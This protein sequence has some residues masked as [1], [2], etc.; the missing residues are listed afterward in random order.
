MNLNRFVSMINQ[1]YNSYN[2]MSKYQNKPNIQVY[3]S[4]YANVNNYY[5]NKIKNFLNRKY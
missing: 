3:S 2:M 5:G 1:A 4:R